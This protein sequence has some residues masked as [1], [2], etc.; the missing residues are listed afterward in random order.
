MIKLAVAI[1]RIPLTNPF[2]AH[3][4]RVF[5][6]RYLEFQ[7]PAYQMAYF[8]HPYYQGNTNFYFIIFI[9]NL[10]IKVYIG[11]GLKDGGFRDV[12]LTSI[13]LW[14][15]LGHSEESSKELVSQLRRFEARLAPFDLPY[16]TGI[17]T[18][19]I[20]WGSIR[21]K[22]RRLA[23]LADRIFSINPS[24][25]SCERN[26]STLKWLLGNYRTRTTVTKLE[27][28]A[29]VRSYYMSNIRDG[30]SYKPELTEAELREVI[31]NTA[32]GSVM[33]MDGDD[34]DNDG[35]DEELQSDPDDSQFSS[36]T[37]ELSNTVDLESSYFQGQEFEEVIVYI[38]NDEVIESGNMD[39]NPENILDS[40]LSCER[41]EE[42]ER[43]EEERE[44]EE[45]E[46]EEREE[47]EREEEEREEE[48]SE[49]EE[50]EEEERE[51][52]ETNEKE[53]REDENEDE[54]EEKS[55]RK[56]RKKEKGKGKQIDE[57]ESEEEKF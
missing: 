50:R 4:I 5:N 54:D 44:E 24:Q 52:E 22:P 14:Q 11:L 7:N 26:F 15:S 55:K 48:E 18:P 41:G 1:Y 39:Y 31:R 49:E 8:M 42:E 9:T 16:T 29:K 20:W 2:K 3:A 35:D 12:A 40:F 43:E 47:E 53:E 57:R 28:M 30:L 36:T 10:L 37:L 38:D 33:E 19:S 13:R 46:E 45:R 25:A 21:T 23:E 51:D 32:I 27:G 17:D 6:R 56:E 34:D